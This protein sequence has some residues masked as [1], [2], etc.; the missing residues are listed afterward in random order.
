VRRC[1]YILRCGVL[2][3]GADCIALWDV[4]TACEEREVLAELNG[5]V[6]VGSLGNYA[7]GEKPLVAGDIDGHVYVY[8]FVD[9][10]Y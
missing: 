8:D 9:G 6:G 10:V 4:R 2:I 5:Q 1:V 7:Q 3:E